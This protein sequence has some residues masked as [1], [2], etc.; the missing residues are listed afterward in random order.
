MSYADLITEYLKIEPSGK[1]VDTAWGQDFRDA[2][3]LW[4]AAEIHLHFRKLGNKS[5]PTPTSVH[6]SYSWEDTSHAEQVLTNFSGNV[7]V[8]LRLEKLTGNDPPDSILMRGGSVT[9][10]TA[11]FAAIGQ[12]IVKDGKVRINRTIKS[13]ES[14]KKVARRKR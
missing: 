8:N 14:P 3:A 9:P 13:G 10:R 5:L 11:I 12:V 7:S 4:I 2:R 1:S 6:V